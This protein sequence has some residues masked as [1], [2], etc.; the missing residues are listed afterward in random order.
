MAKRFSRINFVI[1]SILVAIGI[2]L[3]VCSFKIP[4][5]PNDYAGFA[6]AI[7]SN[8]DV[9]KG[10]TA[11]YEIKSIEEKELTN[12]QKSNTIDFVREVLSAQGY[13]FNQVG[14]ENDSLIRVN[15][16]NDD[17]S[18]EILN[19]L[20]SRV[21]IVIRGQAT[22]DATEY[23]ILANRISKCSATYQST[24]STKS[25]YSFG[26]YIELDDLGTK[27]FEKLTEYVKDNGN[28][29]YFYADGEQ[30]GSL[31]E[32]SKKVTN[33]KTFFPN[34]K[35][36]TESAT[37]LYSVNVWAGTQDTK[38][39]VKENSVTTAYLGY[40]VALFIII[41]LVISFVL[42]AIFLIVRYRDLGL[43][44][45][46][47]NVINVIIYLFLLQ[48]L[49]IVNMTLGTIIGSV[50]G[51]I[52]ATMSQIIVLEKIRN[53]YKLGRRIPLAV[54]LGFKN[55]FFTILDLSCIV[56]LISLSLYFIGYNLLS[57][58]A[59]PLFIG[60]LLSLFSTFVITRSFAKWYLPLNS[61]KPE[62][63]GLKKESK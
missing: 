48:A 11:V 55:S 21:E 28:T 37:K 42:V 60:A 50:L 9:G 47:T 44:A 5:Y 46:F 25:S 35:L 56:A 13:S 2:I 30:L 17:N 59:I 12:S 29:I 34:S 1:V 41:S 3:S 7:S 63:L 54:K 19:A 20:A 32:I 62:H 61:T 22:A 31:A 49:P 24:S 10:Q 26:V 33:G 4:F 36:T 8:Y 16:A 57:A 45:T 58:V 52:F 38:L 6:G 43:L 18:R 40:N 51:F 14:L 15:I 53:E 27:Q 39:A 23:D